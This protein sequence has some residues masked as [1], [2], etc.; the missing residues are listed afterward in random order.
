M[1]NKIL[2]KIGDSLDNT[3]GKY[4]TNHYMNRMKNRIFETQEVY[5][6]RVTIHDEASGYNYTFTLHDVTII[7]E[8]DIPQIIT[9]PLIFNPTELDI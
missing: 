1:E 9:K 3:H 5:S 2:V 4:E 6:D 8:K 7:N